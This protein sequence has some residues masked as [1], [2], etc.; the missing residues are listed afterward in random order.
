MGLT[1]GLNSSRTLFARAYFDEERCADGLNCLRRYCWKV[2]P[3]TRVY[4]KEP[5]HDDNSH[6]SDAYRMA[7]V[8]LTEPVRQQEEKRKERAA[9]VSV[10]S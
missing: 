4:S 1:N 6:G 10:W 8:G 3:I 9:R 5:L 7:A 2:D